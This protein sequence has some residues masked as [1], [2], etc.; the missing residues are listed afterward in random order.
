MLFYLQRQVCPY[1]KIY[2]PLLIAYSVLAYIN[3]VY[4]GK[5]V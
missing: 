2:G 4:S 5:D 3:S 1:C